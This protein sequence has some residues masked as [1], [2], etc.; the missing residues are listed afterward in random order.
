LLMDAETVVRILYGRLY[1]QWHQ[2][3]ISIHHLK[4]HKSN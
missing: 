1:K 2:W 4:I 3:T